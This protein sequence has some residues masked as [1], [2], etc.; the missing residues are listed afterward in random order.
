MLGRAAAQLGLL[1]IVAKRSMSSVVLD[2]Q[3]VST[4]G[5]VT[6]MSSFNVGVSKDTPSR[7]R[8]P[9]NTVDVHDAEAMPALDMPV[10]E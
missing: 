1:R 7:G 10:A 3:R 6:S 4:A 2:T 9:G 5:P 8:L